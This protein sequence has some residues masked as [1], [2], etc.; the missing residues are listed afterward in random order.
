VSLFYNRIQP[1]FDFEVMDVVCVSRFKVAQVFQNVGKRV[2][3]RYWDESDDTS[4]AGIY[5]ILDEGTFIF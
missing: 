4:L 1:G 3:V 2:Y 5:L